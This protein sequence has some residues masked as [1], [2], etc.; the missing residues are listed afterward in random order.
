MTQEPLGQFEIAG[1]FIEKT[2]CRM[3]ERMESRSSK[4]LHCVDD[5][6]IADLSV[7]A[8]HP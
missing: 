8:F 1:L 3:P 2:G 5:T 6:W 7:R 4:S